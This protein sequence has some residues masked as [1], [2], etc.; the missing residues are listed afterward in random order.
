[1]SVLI[2]TSATKESCSLRSSFYTFRLSHAPKWRK[3]YVNIEKSR[4]LAA[5][6]SVS[7]GSSLRPRTAKRS[8]RTRRSA[9]PLRKRALITLYMSKVNAALSCR[10]ALHHRYYITDLYSIYDL[11]DQQTRPHLLKVP[12]LA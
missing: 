2:L 7:S 3:E 5:R 8:Y 10:S 12:P 11:T 9:S 6:R 1:M 4:H